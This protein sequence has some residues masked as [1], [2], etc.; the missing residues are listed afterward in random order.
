[1]ENN[2]TTLDES[3]VEILESL[4]KIDNVDELS[5]ILLSNENLRNNFNTYLTL[6]L[7]TGNPLYQFP[8]LHL[9]VKENSQKVVKYLL[10][11][12]FVDK[13]ICDSWDDNIYHI[14]CRMRGADQLFSIIERKT[15]HHLLLNHTRNGFTKS[16]FLIACE[17]NN[18]FIVKRV[19][20]ILESLQ[21]DLTSITNSAMEY[22]AILNSDV[23]VVKYISSIPGIL[24][25]DDILLKAIKY[26]KFD[27]VVYLLN[28]FL[29]RSIPSYLHNHFNIFQFSTL[30]FNQHNNNNNNNNNI[31]NN[32]KEEEILIKINLNEKTKLPDNNNNNNKIELVNEKLV[33]E[34]YKK[35]IDIQGEREY[36]IWHVACFNRDVQVVELIFSLKGIQP[37]ILDK[38]GYN[39]FL[40]ACYKNSNIKVI[41]YIHKLFPSLINTQ[42]NMDNGV[43]IILKN[44]YFQSKDKLNIIHYL[45]LNGI[46]IHFLLKKLNPQ[47]TYRSIYSS[48]YDYDII[49][50]DRN[51]IQYAKV[52]SQDFDYLNNEHDNEAYRKPSFWK[53][54]DNSADERSKGIN[55]W[56]NRFEEHVLRQLSKMIQEYMLNDSNE[57]QKII[58]NDILT[59]YSNEIFGSSINQQKNRK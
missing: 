10:S 7:I 57:N 50:L 22:N 19:Y 43:F 42:I 13:S 48:R 36:R 47:I 35:I 53:E 21:V 4:I 33:K 29:C 46:D 5:N 32:N 3:V 15:P 41:K 20:E 27:I 25:D 6:D 45:Y 17:N 12:D 23:E 18:V 26:S 39:T 28:V 59:F 11:Q 40:L 51:M 1:M 14:I 52:I 55:E 58:Y 54:I 34:N 37:E 16:A 2:E 49:G 9:A 44:V 24:L 38:E 8:L 30:H 31:N 56:K